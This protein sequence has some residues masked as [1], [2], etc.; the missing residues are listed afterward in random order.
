[1]LY[2]YRNK[3]TGAVI[4][5]PSLCKGD[6]ELVEDKAEKAEQKPVEKPKKKANTPK[7]K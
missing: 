6:W 7:K 4:T 2:T 3:V 1:M 5:V